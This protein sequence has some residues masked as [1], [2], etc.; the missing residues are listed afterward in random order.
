V[1]LKAGALVAAHFAHLAGTVCSHPQAEPETEAHRTGKET[2]A[3]W[4][5]RCLPDARVTLEAELPSGQRADVLIETESRRAVLEYQCADLS[6]REW[7]RRHALYRTT[8]I[9]DLWLLGVGCWVSG[10][11]ESSI[12]YRDV[13]CCVPATGGL[14][15]RGS[16]STAATPDYYDSHVI[17]PSELI[18]AMRADGAPLLFLDSLGDRWAAG[19]LI[20]FRPRGG[21]VRSLRGEVTARP[22]NQLPFPWNLMDWP[23]RMVSAE[24]Y[25]LQ[26]RRPVIVSNRGDDSVRDWLRERHHLEEKDLAALF[27]I[28]VPAGMAFDCSPRLW[29]ACLYYR[30]VHGQVGQAWW[31]DEVVT[32][33]RRYLPLAVS[34]G[35]LLRTA[36][37]QYQDLLSAAGLLS[38]PTGR[39]KAR[40]EAD[41]TSMGRCPDPV[42]AQKLATYRRTLAWDR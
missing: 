13:S 8:G 6:S 42:A 1:V 41:F 4:L 15:P 28:L 35:R 37:Y 12:Q 30:F 38:L 16:A 18:R 11:G 40:V 7:R 32:W 21:T 3:Q 9:Q 39:G 19:T 14:A 33:S 5:T 22:L 26:S 24:S 10:I 20:R 23:I 29:Q 25:L 34:S 17:I 2:L 27:G 31:I 36:L